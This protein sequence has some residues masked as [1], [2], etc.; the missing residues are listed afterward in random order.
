LTDVNE[1]VRFN[2]VGTTFAT[3]DAQSVVPLLEALEHEES[4][5]VRIRVASGLAERAWEVPEDKRALAS[6]VLP[7]GYRVAG[8]TIV[9]S[10]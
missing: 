1:N 7:D 2:A 9:Q 5:R 10:A 8:S 3:A 4:L 6:K